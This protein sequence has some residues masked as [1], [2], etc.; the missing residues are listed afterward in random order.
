MRWSALVTAGH[1]TW[2][3]THQH[4]TQSLSRKGIRLTA[5]DPVALREGHLVCGDT[6]LGTAQPLMT[7]AP[8]AALG[9][10]WWAA[11]ASGD[12]NRALADT[13]QAADPDCDVLQHPTIKFA[14]LTGDQDST[15]GR[16]AEVVCAAATALLTGPAFTAIPV[17]QQIII[18]AVQIPTVDTP[19]FTTDQVRDCAERLPWMPASADREIEGALHILGLS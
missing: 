12:A 19:V 1:I 17:G 15:A 10:W 9:Q 7:L 8:Q 3:L 5:A 13:L 6:H 16:A 4:L 18:S 2:H 11:K 14:T